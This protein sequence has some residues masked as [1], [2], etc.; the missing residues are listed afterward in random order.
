MSEE[1]DSHCKI[2]LF[3]AQVGHGEFHGPK[4]RG[5]DR[6]AGSKRMA[7]AVASRPWSPRAIHVRVGVGS[8]I[9]ILTFMSP[10]LYYYGH[11][12][13]CTK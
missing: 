3:K 8:C 5:H 4:T 12:K 7:R 1:C 10:I 11:Y 2:H 6:F 9:D 13:S